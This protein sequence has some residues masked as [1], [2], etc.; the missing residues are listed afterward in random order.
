MQ[1][2]RRIANENDLELF[3][4]SKTY[5]EVVDFVI[6]LNNATID[7]KNGFEEP[8]SPA[9][10]ALQELLNR[11]VTAVKQHPAKES[12]S[13]FG[14]PEFREFYEDVEVNCPHWIAELVPLNDSVDLADI[15]ENLA[16]ISGY[17][18]ESFG[19]KTR[20]DYGSGHELNFVCFMLCLVK[21][22]VLNRSDFRNLVN[23]VF[24]E[25][26]NVMRLIQQTYWLE[27]AG[28]HGV[29]GLDDYHFLP[30]LFGSAQLVND[31]YVRPIS[32]HDVDIVDMYKDINMYFWSIE[33]INR[34]KTVGLRWHSPMLDDISGVKKWAKV[35]EGMIKMYR[36]E[37]LGKLPIV[38]HFLFGSI[39]PAP[40]G[41]TPA[42][43]IG[44]EIHVQCWA[45]CCGIRVPSAVAASGANN[46][47]SSGN[48]SG[49]RG[50][51]LR[52]TA[53]VPLD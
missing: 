2:V 31:P 1:P 11:V 51:I 15:R 39:L 28:S 20:I 5:A 30:F 46:S 16:E 3:H 6:E 8:V 29:W 12:D 40:E 25:Y 36:A 23:G 21:I 26:L 18:H 49:G 35:N 34:V 42:K 24:F 14:K 41:T 37:V 7:Q 44:E 4:N 9:V 45:D 33:F 32:I 13:R 17:F 50:H 47:N 52:K 19:N 48:N 38:Q 22:R 43:D 53:A 10:R 27:P